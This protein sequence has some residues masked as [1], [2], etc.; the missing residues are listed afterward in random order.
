[1]KS[2]ENLYIYQVII[3]IKS[4]FLL[5]NKSLLQHTKG[6]LQS[7]RTIIIIGLNKA[8]KII[9]GDKVVGGIIGAID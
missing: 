3:K 2:R 6:E 8:G 1:M 7:S 9:Q 4:K 5:T